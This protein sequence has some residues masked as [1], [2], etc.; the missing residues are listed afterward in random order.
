MHNASDTTYYNVDSIMI[1]DPSVSYDVL[2][3]DIPSVPFVDYW[4][5]LFSFNKTFLDHLH[6]KWE[7][8]GYADFYEE[9]LSFPP[10]GLLP[11]PPNLHGNR[12]DCSLWVCL[13]YCVAECRDGA[14][15]SCT[16]A[17]IDSPQNE[18]YEAAPLVNPCWNVYQ[19]STIC[20]LLWDVLGFPGSFAYQPE[21]TDIYFNRT[22]VQ[23][24]INAP[25]REWEECS[26]GVLDNDDSPPSGLSVLPRVIEKNQRTVIGHGML[27][28]ILLAN[29]T[30]M[31]IQNMTWNGAQGFSKFP[32]EEFFV[33][34]HEEL[35]LGTLT[36]AGV[37]GRYR[38]ER[39]LTYVEVNLSGHMQPQM[40]A[41]AA[42]RHL[43]YL[44][45]RVPDL[46]SRLPFTTQ[47]GD[48][49]NGIGAGGSN[50]TMAL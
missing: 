16:D 21:G 31:T 4:S 1:Y 8:C 23:R 44:L 46:G 15:S 39:N 27:D 20:P 29:G 7:S 18:I 43:E 22:D 50:A 9:A 33:P 36:G 19:V 30:L 35:N 6:E 2:L 12:T 32:E 38:T 26:N 45:G 41:G 14:A 3:N 25:I 42:Y 34:Y 40:A 49:G 11:T 28:F 5:G 37:Q 17:D 48:F 13:Q 10:K 24:A 47:K